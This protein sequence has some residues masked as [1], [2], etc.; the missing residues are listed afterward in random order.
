MGGA[1]APHAE[2]GLRA[3]PLM[4][5][6]KIKYSRWTC[7]TQCDMSQ[8]KY[9]HNWL[10]QTRPPDSSPACGR[11]GLDAGNTGPGAAAPA[12]GDTGGCRSV[13]GLLLWL[14]QRGDDPQRGL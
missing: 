7:R 6:S 2:M 5:I 12:S 14:G 9:T 3:Q 4:E 11:P 13:G 8:P 1:Q 10:H